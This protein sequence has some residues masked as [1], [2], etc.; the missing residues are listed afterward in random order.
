MIGRDLIKAI[1]D[2]GMVN[3]EIRIGVVKEDGVNIDLE[4]SIPIVDIDMA[5][6]DSGETEFLIIPEFV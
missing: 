6:M 2:K 4:T 1:L 5:E 3:E